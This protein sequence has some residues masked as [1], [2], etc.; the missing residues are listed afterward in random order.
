[1]LSSPAVVAILFYRWSQRNGEDKFFS[2]FG[3]DFTNALKRPPEYSV[4]FFTKMHFLPLVH[5]SQAHTRAFKGIFKDKQTLF[6][7]I[8]K[9]E[10]TASHVQRKRF[11]NA[12]AILHTM[13]NH[14]H[15]IQVYGV[16]GDMNKPMYM[17]VDFTGTMSLDILLES[18][19]EVYN[20]PLNE[21]LSILNQVAR[22]L[23]HVHEQGFAHRNICARSILYDM[24]SGEC[25]VCLL[26]L[27]KWHWSFFCSF[28]Q[29]MFVWANI[30]KY[31]S[32][33]GLSTRNTTRK[34]T[35]FLL[36]TQCLLTF[37]GVHW[38][39]FVTMFFRLKVMCGA[40][41]CSC[42]RFSQKGQSRMMTW[43]RTL[44]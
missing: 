13:R 25:K 23:K 28:S 22:G 11:Y 18:Q 4:N 30:Y 31:I 1:M 5:T 16:V 2:Q 33:L 27:L 38:K 6:C 20:L 10:S 7:T 24:R 12:A 39:F 36:N 19:S 9:M 29:D 3:L 40:L 35:L 44:M 17:L 34:M 41:A 15:V 32:C 37:A 26:N 21:R 14:E 8:L 43:N 42:T